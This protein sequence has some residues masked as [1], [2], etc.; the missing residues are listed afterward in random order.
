MDERQDLLD[1]RGAG[2]VCF[3]PYSPG[4]NSIAHCWSNRLRALKPWM[5]KDFLEALVDAFATL[6]GLDI[7]SWFRYCG[8]QIAFT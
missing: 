4:L 1:A 8:G 2:V 7:R 5:V 6:T 3:S